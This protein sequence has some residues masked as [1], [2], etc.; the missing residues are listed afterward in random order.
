[1]DCRVVILVGYNPMG[2]SLWVCLRVGNGVLIGY[3]VVAGG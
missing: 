1:M 2:I 3:R